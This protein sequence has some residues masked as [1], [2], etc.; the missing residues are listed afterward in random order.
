MET[1]MSGIQESRDDGVRKGCRRCGSCCLQGG[2]ALHRQDLALI[3]NGSLPLDRLITIRRGELVD[4]PLL[5]RTRSVEYELVKISGTGRQ[6][7]CWYYTD[8][9]GCTIYAQRPAACRALRCW[10]PEEVLALVGKD[11]LTR[12]D[13]LPPGHFLRPLVEEHESL[14][15]CPD[16]EKVRDAVLS[17]GAPDL[18]A[19]QVLVDADMSFRGRMV[20]EHALPLALELFAFGRPLFQLL[21]AAGIACTE[22]NGRIRLSPAKKS[23]SS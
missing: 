3:E 21:Q 1:V 18:P 14:C 2:P 11:L 5:N 13:I 4:D 17:G 6:W 12:A 9:T 15:P 23:P 22:T 16:M 10:D 7:R 8:E 20:R 19:L